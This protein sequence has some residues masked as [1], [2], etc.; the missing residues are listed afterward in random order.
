MNEEFMCLLRSVP[1][2]LISFANHLKTESNKIIFQGHRPIPFKFF[3]N[4]H[5][6][7]EGKKEGYIDGLNAAAAYLEKWIKIRT[8]NLDEEDF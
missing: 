2:K 3:F 8:T 1:N 7:Y 6:Y 4:K 5:A